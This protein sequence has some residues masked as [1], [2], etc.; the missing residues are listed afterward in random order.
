[1]NQGCHGLF[2][3][4]SI[5]SFQH[6]M[7]TCAPTANRSQLQTYSTDFSHTCYRRYLKNFSRLCTV[8]A[9][10]TRNSYVSPTPGHIFPWTQPF[11]LN[12][13]GLSGGS[14]ELRKLCLER[15]WDYCIF[16]AFTPYRNPVR[17]GSIQQTHAHGRNI[18]DD[19]LHAKQTQ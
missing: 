14:F 10:P 11:V 3:V 7:S 13:G 12:W 9:M 4:G 2:Q 6:A 16:T 1:M 17:I 19:Q 18:S 15:V 8:Y 5:H